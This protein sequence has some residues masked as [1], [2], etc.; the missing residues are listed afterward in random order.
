LGSNLPVLGNFT[1]HLYKISVI[2]NNDMLVSHVIEMS[3]E[4]EEEEKEI[5]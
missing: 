2:K 3:E 4:E 5:Q 1:Q